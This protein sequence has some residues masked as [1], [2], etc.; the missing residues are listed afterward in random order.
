[1]LSQAFRRTFA[2]AASG[3]QRVNGVALVT[4]AGQGIGKAIAT[5]LASDGFHVALNDIGKNESKVDSVAREIEERT[6]QKTAKVLADV[7]KEPEVKQMFDDA[8][9]HLGG[10]DVMVANA[11]IAI[12]QP[13]HESTV[14]AWDKTFAINGRGVMLCYKYAADVMKKQ[15]RGGRIIGACSVAGR[16]GDPDSGAYSASKFAV[17]GLSQTCALEL[18]PYGINVNCYAPGAIQTDLLEDIDRVFTEKEK[19]TKGRW[20]QKVPVGIPLGRL[21]RPEDVA[22]VVSFLASP[23]SA[24]VTGQ[25][26]TI[27]GGTLFD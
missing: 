8:V 23:D 11:G 20:L 17:R 22:G 12:I 14:D 13:L 25:T 24:F 2:T 6:G 10:L 1:M 3:A 4:G 27:D 9:G 26:I 19:E 16:R 21:G 15:G 7:A 5:R 18:A